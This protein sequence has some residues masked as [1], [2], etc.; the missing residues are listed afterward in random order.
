LKDLTLPLEKI[1]TRPAISA[2]G[3]TPAKDISFEIF[4]GFFSG[5]PVTDENG[6]VIHAKVLNGIGG[7]CDE[8]ALDAI[9]Q[10]KFNPGIQNGKPI[11]VQVT[12][13]IWFKLQ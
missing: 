6:K 4:Y 7:G 9:K 1:M 13:P 11:K 3:N 12:I 10:T 5:M 2:R 8:V